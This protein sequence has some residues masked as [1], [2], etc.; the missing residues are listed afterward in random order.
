MS[1]ELERALRWGAVA[2][3]GQF[4][5]GEKIPYYEHVVGVA[6]IL[7][8][9]GFDEAVVIAGLLHDVVEDTERTL[10]QVRER[11]GDEVAKVVEACSEI[12]TDG[13]GRKRPWIDR[14][15]D[16]LEALASA[17]L[18]VKAVILA[19]KLHNLLSIACDLEEG[20][21][22]WSIFN[23]SRADVLWYYRSTVDLVGGGDPRLN[24]LAERCRQLLDGLA[25][26]E[27]DD[28]GKR[29]ETREIQE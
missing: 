16:H 15:R 2:H 11:F 24:R 9:L 22:V 10:D 27:R 19:D 25:E 26:D 23:A 3:D 13:Q 28:S 7:D 12:K 14:K 20:R 17:P 1:F 29:A 18:E 4:R 5:K 8:R 21:P 6:M